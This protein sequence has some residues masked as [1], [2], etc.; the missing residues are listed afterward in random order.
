MTNP[1]RVIRFT[2]ADELAEAVAAQLLARL[3]EVQQDGP[4][5]LCLTGGRI[6]NRMYEALATLAEDSALDPSLMHIWW[7]DERFVPLTDPDRNATQSFG[8]LARTMTFTP[9]QTHPMPARDGKA[10]AH[11]AAFAY[12]RELGDTV[13]DVCL[14]GMGED[15]HVAS[16][17]PNHPS[18]QNTMASAV[19]GVED[20]PK[21]P[22]E[23]MSLTM[24]AINRSRAVWMLVSGAG[25]AEALTRAMGGDP[26]LPASAVRGTE[27]TLWFLDAEAA[28]LLPRYNCLL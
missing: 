28:S 19:I 15:G 27:E 25:K 22:P 8:I 23:R 4:V 13:F 26:S 6:A 11:E 14:L 24:N 16:L 7:G 1:A 3:I 21:P 5:H 9:G 18:F 12:A 17:F 2:N 20:A 10:D